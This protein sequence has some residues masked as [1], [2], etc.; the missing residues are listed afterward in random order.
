[1]L[2]DAMEHELQQA[3]NAVVVAFVDVQQKHAIDAAA[4]STQ[5]QV[6][7]CSWVYMLTWAEW[8]GICSWHGQ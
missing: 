7:T 5:L 3:L 1:M 2:Q 4:F 6:C 8:L